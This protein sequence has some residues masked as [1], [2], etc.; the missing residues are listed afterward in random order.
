M[1]TKAEL[2]RA[3][4]AAADAAPAPVAA[5]IAPVAPAVAAVAYAPAPVA[6]T[7]AVDH[8]ALWDKA[9][10]RVNARVRASR[11]GIA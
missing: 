3:I 11:V 4:I 6:S 10:A 9:I 2:V 7:P 5:S 8:A 1:T